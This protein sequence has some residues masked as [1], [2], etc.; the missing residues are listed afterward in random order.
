MEKS[1]RKIAKFLG[2]N[3]S[4]EQVDMVKFYVILK[5]AFPM[6]RIIVK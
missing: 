6:M 3:L 1:I 5:I 4:D 2:R